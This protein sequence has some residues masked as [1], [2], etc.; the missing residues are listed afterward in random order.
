MPKWLGILISKRQDFQEER[1]SRDDT[2]KRQ[3]VKRTRIFNYLQDEA[4]TM[5]DDQETSVRE[6]KCQKG[7]IFNSL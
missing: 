4:P 3:E 5:Q 6:A 2:S 1:S 7:K